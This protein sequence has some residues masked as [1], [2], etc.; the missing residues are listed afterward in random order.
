M[1][2]EYYQARS[3]VREEKNGKIVHLNPYQGCF[4]DCVYCDGKAEN[5][6]MH[7]DFGTRLKV[8]ENAPE[9]LEQYL[10]KKGYLPVNRKKTGTLMDMGIKPPKQPEKIIVGISG[11][12]CDI[13]QPAEEQ[14]GMA[15]K[16]MRIVYD[17]GLPIE[18][19]TK[20][21]LV[22]KDLDLLKKINENTHATVCMSIVFSRENEHLRE[23][24]EPRA[25]T[26]SE[27]FETLKILHGEG[28]DTGIWMMPV[29]PWI[30]DSGENMESMVRDAA[31]AGVRFVLP[32]GLT[33]KP[34]R[35]KDGVMACLGE[36]FPELVEKYAGM[37]GNNNKWGAP[38]REEI[39][40]LGT[41]NWHPKLKRYCREY[42]I[43]LESW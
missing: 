34:G 12:V 23:I 17:Y 38:D 37:Y 24:F 43:K 6:H 33:L 29:L 36:H 32:G 5:Y 14:V 31:D 39:V 11:G 16:M 26:I 19:L 7:E 41:P 30:C 35:Q 15:R 28:I 10:R 8:K 20:N 2:I 25:S 22:L 18:L 4:H 13:Y 42:G 3:L 21:K 40:R 27:R 1:E 9:L